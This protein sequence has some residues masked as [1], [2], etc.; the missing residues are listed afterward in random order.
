MRT[1]LPPQHKIILLPSSLLRLLLLF[2]CIV[3]IFFLVL[4]FPP[5]VP[6]PPRR[7][8]YDRPNPRLPPS[9][10][11]HPPFFSSS[12]PPLFLFR[13]P[14]PLP[15][16]PLPPPRLVRRRRGRRKLHSGSAVKAAR[17]S[18]RILVLLRYAW[19]LISS[20]DLRAGTC[21]DN[22]RAKICKDISSEPDRTAGVGIQTSSLK[23]VKG[24]PAL[25]CKR[26]IFRL[27]PLVRFPQLHRRAQNKCKKTS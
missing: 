22:F 25:A 15:P 19:S 1:H 5:A 17:P 4:I 21:E 13:P 6:L 16:L 14:P 27:A 18:Q 10:P 12:P 26:V 3:I 7:S 2:F 20:L 24:P 8:R 11:S 23:L 9:P